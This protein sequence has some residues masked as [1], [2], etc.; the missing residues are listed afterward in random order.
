MKHLHRRLLVL[1]SASYAGEDCHR[2][3]RLWRGHPVW[4]RVSDFELGPFLLC[5]ERRH[6]SNNQHQCSDKDRHL[7]VRLRE[8]AEFVE[9]QAA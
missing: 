4:R 2:V 8:T 9:E 3:R 5:G 6:A 1:H 7:P